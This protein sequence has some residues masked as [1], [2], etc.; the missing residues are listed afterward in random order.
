MSEQ[1]AGGATAAT[2][3]SLG[4]GIWVGPGVLVENLTVFAVYAKEPRDIGDFTT[5]E[6]AMAAGTA[7]IREVGGDGPQAIRGGEEIEQQQ[8]Q[9]GGGARVDTLVI[10]NKDKLPILILAGTMVKGGKQDRQI[11]EDVVVPS[12]K[13]LDIS[14]FCVEQGRWNGTRD[15]KDTGGKFV[16]QKVLATN[17]VRAAGQ[18]DKDQSEV[19]KEV[20]SANSAHDK[21]SASGT[22]MASVD[23]EDLVRRRAALATAARS[24]L[25]G[26]T[27]QAH[28]VGLAYAVDG[29]VRGVRWFAGP[30]LFALFQDTL[31]E[32]AAFE[33]ITA[34]AEAKSAGRAVQTVAAKD[35]AV[36]QFTDDLMAAPE[37][38]REEE[39][40]QARSL[41]KAKGGYSSELRYDKKGAPKA[42]GTASPAAESS[43]PPITVDLIK[44]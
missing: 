25:A 11:G 16:P 13:T 20:A 19:W 32:T 42:A 39:G 18:H 6:K 17:K 15:G 2:G 23:D 9:R 31:L 34:Q 12:G 10:E 14:A 4:K 35:S 27:D 8:V 38:S 29:E 43:A 40:E 7:E 1:T 30:K 21:K 5:I 3:P 24:V 26:V 36:V 44:K 22:F 37:T 28:L 41:K 33:A